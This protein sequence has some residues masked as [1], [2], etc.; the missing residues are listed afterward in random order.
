MSRILLKDNHSK[1]YYETDGDTHRVRT[2]QNVDEL[3]EHAHAMR[4]ETHGQRYGDMRQVAVIPMSVVG[5]AM[6][7]GWLFDQN[8]VRKWVKE[9]P[10]FM[11]FDRGF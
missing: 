7:E 9:H 10:E 5:Q 4:T 11:T 2:D 6:R 3:L 1:T 8:Q